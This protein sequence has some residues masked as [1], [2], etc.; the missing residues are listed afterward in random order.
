MLPGLCASCRRTSAL[1][2]I[3]LKALMTWCPTAEARWPRPGRAAI[4]SWSRAWLMTRASVEW[5]PCAVTESSSTDQPR[6][7]PVGDVLNVTPFAELRDEDQELGARHVHI[8]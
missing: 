6:L 1:L 8:D 7:G 2:T 3:A 4:A 5:V